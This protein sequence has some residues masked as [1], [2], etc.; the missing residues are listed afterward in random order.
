MTKLSID[1]LQPPFLSSGGYVHV[2]KLYKNDFS[3]KF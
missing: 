2:F 3:E 1:V